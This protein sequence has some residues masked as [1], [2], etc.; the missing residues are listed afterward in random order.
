LSSS[1][2]HELAPTVQ[3]I[4]GRNLKRLRIEADLRQEDLA[5]LARRF[6]LTWTAAT[7]A[8]IET[9]RRA[10]SVEELLVLPLALRCALSE[11]LDTDS[12]SL[13]IGSTSVM[14]SALFKILTDQHR[15]LSKREEM[16]V[17]ETI[18]KKDTSIVRAMRRANLRDN[19]KTYLHMAGARHGEAELKA[20]QALKISVEEVAAFALRC[21]ERSLTDERDA[22]AETSRDSALDLRAVR[23]HLTRE[24]RDELRKEISEGKKLHEW[25]WSE[26]PIKGSIGEWTV[27]EFFSSRHFGRG[28]SV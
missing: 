20:A 27:A 23:G 18:P 8:A 13:S 4:V 7:V 14:H 9:D 6:G 28:G 16:P 24:L 19:M 26:P 2:R 21:W 10:V 12:R 3:Q 25:D 15:E 1:E 5:E 22:R 17:D 11:F